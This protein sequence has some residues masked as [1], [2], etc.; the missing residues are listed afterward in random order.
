MENGIAI[1]ISQLENR[2]QLMERTSQ[3]ITKF[4]TER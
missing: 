4:L 2:Q 3:N 1:M